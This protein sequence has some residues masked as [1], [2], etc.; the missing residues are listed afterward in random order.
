MT[1]LEGKVWKSAVVKSENNPEEWSLPY[2]E[3]SYDNII[4][5]VGGVLIFDDKGSQEELDI[6]KDQVSY[7]GEEG[8]IDY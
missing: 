5:S 7:F 3:R 4:T 1:P 8:T 2:F 6:I